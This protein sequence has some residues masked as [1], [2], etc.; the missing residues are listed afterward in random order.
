MNCA[1]MLLVPER[2]ADWI[3]LFMIADDIL[4]RDKRSRRMKIDGMQ[5]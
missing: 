2:I 1:R 5:Y 3:V 4:D